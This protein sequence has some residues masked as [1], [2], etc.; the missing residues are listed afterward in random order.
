MHLGYVRNGRVRSLEQT[1]EATVRGDRC[2]HGSSVFATRTPTNGSDNG[3]RGP[4]LLPR[5]SYLNLVASCSRVMILLSDTQEL[6]WEPL[7]YI[8]SP[9]VSTIPLSG[10]LDSVLPP[11]SADGRDH[12]PE[13][14]S[15]ICGRHG[16]T[17][18]SRRVL[19]RQQLLRLRR[20][21]ALI[22]VAVC[23]PA[24][25][26]NLDVSMS[27]RCRWRRYRRRRPSAR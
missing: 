20:D 13:R 24:G 1:A 17:L 14:C 19:R 11:S 16:Q 8:E 6:T 3:R 5:S 18:R 7:M 9:S 2:G 27:R 15:S 10:L 21:A 23:P 4:P 25:T 22:E 26:A 12:D